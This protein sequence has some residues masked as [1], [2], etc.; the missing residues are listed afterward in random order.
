MKLW[1]RISL[2]FIAM[3]AAAAGS[4]YLWIPDSSTDA[5]DICLPLAGLPPGSSVSYLRQKNARAQEQES[6]LS[7]DWLNGHAPQG[8]VIPVA[9]WNTEGDSVR[10]RLFEGLDVQGAQKVFAI[11]DLHGNSNGSPVHSRF[12]LLGSD[13]FGRDMFSRLILGGRISLGIGFCAVLLSM[14]I[15]IAVGMLAAYYGGFTDRLLSWFM[16][17]MWSIPSML[18]ALAVSF[19]LG[20]GFVPILVAIGLSTWVD[21]ARMVRGQVLSLREREFVQAGKVLGY[22]G[23]RIMVHHIL[24]NLRQVL[25]VVASATFASAILLEAGL[26]FL[27]LGIAPPIPSWGNMVR[28]HYGYLVLGKAY[29]ALVPGLTIMATVLAFQ[30]LSNQLRDYWDIRKL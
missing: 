6:A 25:L 27:G 17:V 19:A 11:S 30:M 23:F 14:L 7:F 26:S 18:L 28:E 9:S 10:V 13:R 20:K 21:V 1:S 22:S 24:P 5:N 4:A 3:M 15:G 29:L 8:A 16:G 12:F 2:L